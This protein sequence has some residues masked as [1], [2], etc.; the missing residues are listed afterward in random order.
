MKIFEIWKL[1]FAEFGT[2]I[3]RKVRLVVSPETTGENRVVIVHVNIPPGG[4][5]DGHL[6]PDSDEYIYFDGQGAVILDGIRKE[7]KK[8]TMV[9]AIKGVMHE[10]INTSRKRE[11]SLLCIFVPPFKPYGS[12]PELIEKTRD[13]L[14]K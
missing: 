8:G 14:K 7:V 6:H 12:Y 5:S 4:I 1:P 3:K 9:H 2:G 10:C 11:L 13:F